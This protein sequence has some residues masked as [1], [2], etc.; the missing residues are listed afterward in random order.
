MFVSDALVFLH[1]QKAA[2][3]YAVD[4]LARALPGQVC[5]GHGALTEGARGRLVAAAIRD[6]WD[7]YVSLWSYGCMGEGAVR[8][9][10]VEPRGVLRGALSRRA[11]RAV[12]T[13][14]M[15]AGEALACLRAER[16]RDPAFWAGTY[17]ATGDVAGD[18]VLFRRWLVAI[19]TGPGAGHLPGLYPALPMCG[20]VGF[21][22]YRV[23]EL[24][25]DWRV[26]RGARRRIATPGAALDFYHRHGIVDA[27][28]RTERIE[29]DLADLLGRV[30]G[31]RSGGA[32]PLAAAGVDVAGA[33]R[34]NR[35]RR[36]RHAAYYDAETVAL[37]AEKDRLVVE[38]FGYAPPVPGP[39]TLAGSECGA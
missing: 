8:G 6:P 11:G 2:G 21:L 26:W 24:F 28:L 4:A 25:T 17:A 36:G 1:L 20:A 12:L 27:V 39:R 32:G 33:A 31:A 3:T 34:A 22:S 35:S 19:L 7:W 9:R 38:T 15:R 5:R 18:A 23:L 37:V 30:A 29:A 14:E 16:G 10:L 13:G